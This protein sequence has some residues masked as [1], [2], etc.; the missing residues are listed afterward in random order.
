MPDDLTAISEST[1]APLRGGIRRESDSG[2]FIGLANPKRHPKSCI[3]GAGCSGFTT[4]KALQ[5]R[6]LD[7][8]CFE[9][10]DR[11]GGNWAF[12]NPNGMSACYRSLH[13]DTSKHRMQ[14]EDLPI[15]EHF[16][17]FPHHSQ[18][19]EYFNQYVDHFGLRERITFSTTVERCTRRTDGSWT[20][21]T[22][23]PNGRRQLG[24]YD[25]LLVANGHHWCPRWPDPMPEGAFSGLQMHSHAYLSPFEPHDL[26]GKSIVVVGMGNSAMDIASELSQRSISKRLTVSARR[27]VWVF[28]KYI[29]G[30][31]ADKTSLPSW[32]PARVQRW[33]AKRAILR[34]VGR[35]ESY[36]LPTPDHDPLE[37]HPSVSAEFLTRCGSGDIEVRGP[38]DRLDDDTVHFADGH[39]VQ[40]DAIVYATGYSLS[41]PFLESLDLPLQDNHLPLFKRVFRPELS[42]LMFLGLA[43]SLPT[44]VNLAERQSRW[45][46]AYLL[47]EYHLPTAEHMERIIERDER[48]FL[49]HYYDSPRHRMQVD[50][51]AYCADL[52]REW[53]R[54]EKRAARSANSLPVPRLS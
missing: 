9:A 35:M 27:G 50:F 20:V 18:V 16:P 54:G 33:L 48:R 23:G 6:G 39:S 13:I 30:Q 22:L 40:A 21:E 53:R 41:F 19:L 3:I 25:A 24:H 47:G 15:P 52:E 38:I 37:A 42:N 1:R 28:P 32:V 34:S 44:L 5:D 8:D 51:A 4:A 11:I 14:F 10:S 46:A 43:Q 49:G 2:A 26:R 12:G 45:I 36:G 7:F 31:P 29:N 17:D